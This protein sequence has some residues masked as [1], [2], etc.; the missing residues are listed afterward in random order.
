[1]LASD[2]DS[3]ILRVSWVYG[4]WGNFLLTM[5]RLMAECD[6]LR[7]VDD[8]VGTPTWCRRIAETTTEALQRMLGAETERD[9][10]SGL[11][12]FA[13]SG[14]TSWY[15]FASAIRDAGGFDCDLTPISTAEYPTL[16]VRPANSRLDAGKLRHAFGITP[17]AWD[18]ESGGMRPIMMGR[19]ISDTKSIST[20]PLKC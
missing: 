7:I 3:L 1:M 4:T 8:Q 14:E 2:C 17:P 16:A 6:V 13:P 20:L 19:L 18:S 5:M 10:L 15:S 11:Y 12:H 9:N